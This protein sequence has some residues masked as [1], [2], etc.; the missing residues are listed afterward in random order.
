MAAP[1][2]ASVPILSAVGFAAGG[3][4]AGTLAAT[5]HGSI[6][7]VVAGSGFAIAQSAG[8]GGAGLAVV[9]GAAQVCG[10]VI[11]AGVGGVAWLKSKL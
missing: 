3:V 8:A 5:I 7:N 9:N 6:G 2:L 1:A 4:Q 10:G 11:T